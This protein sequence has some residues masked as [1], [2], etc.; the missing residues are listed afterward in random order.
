MIKVSKPEKPQILQDNAVIWTKELDDFVLHHGDGSFQKIPQDKRK[1][2]DV[3]AA[4][5]NHKEIR[6][7]LEKSSTQGKCMF[8]EKYL[9][10]NDVAV[11]HFHPKSIYHLHTFEWDNLLLSCTS[12]NTGK[13]TLDTKNQAIVHPINDFPETY[14]VFK[15]VRIHVADTAPDKDIAQRTIEK[16]GLRR[17][18]LLSHMADR[19]KEIYDL[20][21]DIYKLLQKY[22]SSKKKK[23]I[24]NSLLEA[25]ASLQKDFFSQ[26]SDKKAFVGYTRSAIRQSPIIQSAVKNIETELS[27]TFTF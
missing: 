9:D 17:R 2:R 25:L 4:R 6:A 22:A 5:Y 20:E 13:G 11:E 3:L 23:T 10:K 26:E 14:F 7:Q 19:A 12:C 24:A 1:E 8:C 18:D 16:C 15:E 27:V 21:D